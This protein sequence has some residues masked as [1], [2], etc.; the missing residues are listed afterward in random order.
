MP[1]NQEL[2]VLI[3]AA[4]RAAWKRKWSELKTA[5]K[6]L[7]AVIGPRPSDPVFVTLT[8]ENA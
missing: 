4:E 2:W 5:R 8:K 3:Q 7:E 1:T 6:A